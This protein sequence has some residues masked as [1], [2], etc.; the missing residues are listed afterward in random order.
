MAGRL[1][2]ITVCETA[3]FVKRAAKVWSDVGREDFIDYIA[4]NPFAGDIIEGTSGVRKVRWGR[5]GMQARRRA[6]CLLCV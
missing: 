2:L 6:R 5:E 4:A 3:D 1:K